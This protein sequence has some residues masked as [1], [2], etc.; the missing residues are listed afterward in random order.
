M[1]SDKRSVFIPGYRLDA[2]CRMYPWI[3]ECFSELCLSFI[4]P[5]K[6]DLTE[7]QKAVLSQKIRY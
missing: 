2:E 6:K 5:E 7:V 1:A 3:R 4:F